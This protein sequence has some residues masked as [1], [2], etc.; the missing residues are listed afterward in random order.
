MFINLVF[1]IVVMYP[2][3][4]GED[5][6]TPPVMSFIGKYFTLNLTYIT[7]NRDIINS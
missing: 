4:L 7:K 6:K 5:R 3:N 2:M 1:Q